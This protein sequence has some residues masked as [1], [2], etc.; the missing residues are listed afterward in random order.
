MKVAIVGGG[1]AGTS[2]AYVLKAAGLDVSLYEA[3]DA[4]AP[5]ASGNDVGLYNPRLSAHRT[6]ESDFYVSAFA[7]AIRTFSH[8]C[9]SDRPEGVEESGLVDGKARSLGFARDD[10]NLID[11]NPCGALHLIVDE[12]KQKRFPQTHEQWGW[13]ED[14]MRLLGS[15]EAS[16]VAG[17]EVKHDALYLPDSGCVSP[18]KLCERYAEGVD[19]HLS[20]GI[21]TLGDIDA[22]IVILACGYGALGFK[23]AAELPLQRVRGQITIV[24][25]TDTSRKVKTNLCYGG[26]FSPALNGSHAL[27]ATFQRWLTH[28]EEMEEDNESN[29]EGLQEI[30]PQL[31]EGLEVTGQRAALRTTTK[32]HFPVVGRMPGHDNL[33]ISAGHGSHGII[34]SIAGAHLLA[35][36]ILGRPLS[37]SIATTACLNPARFCDT[38]DP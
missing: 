13:P 17:V 2:C 3:G 19:V 23:E 32:D 15:V 33:Y 16:E 4:L 12:K 21:E 36:M 20:A 22:D 24:K 9:H 34:S 18:R 29:L 11:W 35:D 5:G 28:E 38:P 7:Q 31:A 30:A 10:K 8:L 25:A 6:P 26:Y 27:G 1:L 14:R 37:Q